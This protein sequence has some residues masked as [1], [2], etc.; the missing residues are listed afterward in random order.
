MSGPLRPHDGTEDLRNG[1]LEAAPADRGAKRYSLLQYAL[2]VPGRGLPL[3]DDGGWNTVP[4]SK[5][6]R[7][8]DTS[9]LT[10]ITKVGGCIGG[11]GGGHGRVKR[12]QTGIEPRF[13]S[14]SPHFLSWKGDG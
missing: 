2:F 14:W 11:S 10:K 1:G 13:G 9:R 6:S 7:P 5:G 4:I 3:V 8:I 12:D